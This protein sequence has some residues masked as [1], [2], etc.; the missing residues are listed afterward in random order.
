MKFR[1]LLLLGA[2]GSG[3]GTQGQLLAQIPG[4]IHLSSGELFRALDPGSDLGKLFRQYSDQGQLVP[5]DLTIRVWQGHV[6]TLID[7]G[8]YHPATDLLVL[9]GIPRN[10]NQLA[11]LSAS[12]DIL[13]VFHLSCPNRD[14]L[15]QRLATRVHQANRADDADPKVILRRITIYETETKPLLGAIPQERIHNIDADQ[16]PYQV[17]R[18]ILNSLP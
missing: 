7:S 5:D 16:L 10:V 2:P 17:L 14:V 6:Q 4:F 11:K 18:Q 1:S 9:D 13:H 8:R 15:I 12:V 3:K